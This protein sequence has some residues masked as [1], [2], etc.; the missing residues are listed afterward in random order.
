MDEDLL[1]VDELRVVDLRE[2]LK[3]R[4]LKVSGLKRELIE[5]LKEAL[6]E[7]D[8]KTQISEEEETINKEIPSELKETNSREDTNIS[9]QESPKA[10]PKNSADFINEEYILILAL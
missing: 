6:K 7:P 1:W 9:S 2:E 3:K 8:G 4:G 10:P 5:R